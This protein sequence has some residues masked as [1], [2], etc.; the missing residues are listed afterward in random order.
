MTLVPECTFIYTP[1]D[2]EN[3]GK[4]RNAAWLL[5]KYCFLISYMCFGILKFIKIHKTL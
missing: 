3:L 5:M 1:P 2:D 4:V